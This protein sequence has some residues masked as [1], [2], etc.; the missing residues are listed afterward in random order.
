MGKIS[1]RTKKPVFKIDSVVKIIGKEH[2]ESKYKIPLGTIG[3]VKKHIKNSKGEFMYKIKIDGYKFNI[4]SKEQIFTEP[5]LMS[6]S[7]VQIDDINEQSNR[8]RITDIDMSSLEDDGA[9]DDSPYEP[10]PNRY[11]RDDWEYSN[12]DN[13]GIDIAQLQSLTLSSKLLSDYL[14]K[15]LRKS[16]KLHDGMIYAV[17]SGDINPVFKV[18]DIVKRVG[19]S[20][21]P[22][23]GYPEGV[24]MIGTVTA[25]REAGIWPP[26][27]N[28]HM[29]K[30]YTVNFPDLHRPGRARVQINV[31]GR[32]LKL[33]K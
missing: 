11:N 23:G 17:T 26:G 6:L 22:D 15:E 3:I 32:D 7:K 10:P 29:P 2:Y 4:K 19:N 16:K 20:F 13:I 14:P 8:K 5:N 31:I 30:L 9:G 21:S 12:S 1:N 18:G 28:R 24:N 27:S 25:I 33:I